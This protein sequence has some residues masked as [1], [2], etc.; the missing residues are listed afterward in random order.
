MPVASEETN[1]EEIIAGG[2][3]AGVLREALSRR[4]GQMQQQSSSK[5][6]DEDSSTATDWNTDFTNSSQLK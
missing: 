5:E 2:D 1:S 3:L 4:R 6:E